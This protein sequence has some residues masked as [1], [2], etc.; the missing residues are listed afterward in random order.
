MISDNTLSQ[1]N[2]WSMTI[3]PESQLTKMLSDLR[4][5]SKGGKRTYQY[6]STDDVR[7][8]CSNSFDYAVGITWKT[9]NINFKVINNYFR[10]EQLSNNVVVFQEVIGQTNID[11]I[12]CATI[13]DF[14]DQLAWIISNYDFCDMEYAI[15]D[16][17]P[18]CSTYR[19][20][21]KKKSLNIQEYKEEENNG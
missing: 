15:I 16:N 12:F 10:M 17:E 18:L 11:I 13:Q 19:Y 14:S 7:Q 3:C 8:A 20:H 1:A 6:F 5:L 4:K 21:R 9:T 2:R